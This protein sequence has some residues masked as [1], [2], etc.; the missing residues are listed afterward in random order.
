MPAHPPEP[1]ALARTLAALLGLAGCAS[2][3]PE[4]AR[5]APPPADAPAAAG[6]APIPDSTPSAAVIAELDASLADYEAQLAHNEVRFAAMGVRVA[7]AE[8][9]EDDNRA[10]VEDGYAPPPPARP[11]ETKPSAASRS[12]RARPVLGKTKQPQSKS[13]EAPRPAPSSDGR[14][15]GSAPA[16]DLPRPEKTDGDR[17]AASAP[18]DKKEREGDRCGEL[19]ELADSTCELETKICDLAARHADEPRYQDVCRRAGE[20]CSLAAEACRQCSP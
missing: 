3:S 14:A 20:D 7:L 1:R 15:A 6:E 13:A 17:K 10:K 5:Y 9:A 16:R 12:D 8:G 18:G 19:C 11:V 2:S 4:A